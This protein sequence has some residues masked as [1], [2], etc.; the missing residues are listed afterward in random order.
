MLGCFGEITTSTCDSSQGQQVLDFAINSTT[1]WPSWLEGINA[2]LNPLE[3]M[4]IRPGTFVILNT[5]SAKHE[6]E[7]Y[8]SIIA[9]LKQHQ[10]SFED[11][12]PNKIPGLMT[13]TSDYVEGVN[14][15]WP[16]LI[17]LLDKDVLKRELIKAGFA[18]ET[19]RILDR[20]DYPADRRLDGRE[21]VGLVGLSNS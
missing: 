11:V 4:H 18:V 19:I 16:K 17:N 14:N 1:L 13:N 12:D 20:T 5:E 9:A 2:A 3:R 7:N 6:N 8:E 10:Q 21:C 15:H